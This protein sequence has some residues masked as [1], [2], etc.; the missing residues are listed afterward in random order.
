M[1]S[2]RYDRVLKWM[3][4]LAAFFLVV[5]LI[6]IFVEPPDDDWMAGGGPRIGIVDIKGI[7]LDSERVVRQLDRF[8]RRKDIDA[9]VVRIDSP[10]GTVAAS[11]EIYAKLRLVRDEGDKPV[12]VSMGTVAASGGVYVAL[13]ADTIMANPGTTTGSIGVIFDFPV[14]AGL[15]EKIGLRIEVVKSGPLK[16]AGSP[17]RDP[18]AADRASFQG[19]ID[20]LYDQFIT[21]VALER[22]LPLETVRKMA[23]G[24]IFTGRQAQALG[25]VDLLGNL[26]DAIKLAGSLTGNLKRPVVVRP[27]ERDRLFPWQHLTGGLFRQGGAIRPLPQYRMR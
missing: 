25:L 13:G 6:S 3:L 10:G 19:V 14:A 22:D 21:V 18:T 27:E 26:E 12:I 1:K 5:L 17:Y 9:L 11:Q 23:T 16:D 2:S 24:E 15:L 20:D 8:S 7:I 4:G